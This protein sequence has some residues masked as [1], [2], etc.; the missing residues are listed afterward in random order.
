MKNK[1]KIVTRFCCRTNPQDVGF[2][3]NWYKN[4]T[5]TTKFVINQS[6][7]K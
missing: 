6:K 7:S 5:Q 4:D 2:D 1:N 3:G